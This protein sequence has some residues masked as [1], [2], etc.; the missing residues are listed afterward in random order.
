MPQRRL[1]TN[2]KFHFALADSDLSL[3]LAKICHN[4]QGGAG[5]RTPAP[6]ALGSAELPHA[7]SAA[8]PHF[9]IV[10]TKVESILFSLAAALQMRLKTSL[11]EPQNFSGVF[12][13]DDLCA[14][15]CTGNHK[16]LKRNP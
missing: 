11:M 3:A 4:W 5:N 16:P 8:L 10:A 7:Y 1:H 15:R 6:S 9:S 13:V 14:V 12:L 2:L